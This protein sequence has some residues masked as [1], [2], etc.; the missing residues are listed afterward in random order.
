[1]IVAMERQRTHTLEIDM[2]I[3]CYVLGWSGACFS[4]TQINWVPTRYEELKKTKK[5][6]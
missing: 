1:M 2:K 6:N 4:P 3:L 5:E